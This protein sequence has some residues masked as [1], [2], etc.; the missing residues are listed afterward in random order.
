MRKVL[1]AILVSS[2]LLAVAPVTALARGDHHRRHDHAQQIRHRHFGMASSRVTDATE[3]QC[4]AAEREMQREEHADRD[5]GDRNDNVNEN[6]GAENSGA[7]NSGTEN[8]GNN[9]TGNDDNGNDNVEKND[10]GD[11]QRREDMCST[12]EHSSGAGD[13]DA[14]VTVARGDA[15]RSDVDLDR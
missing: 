1:F 11:D 13:G 5:R 9:N 8:S 3:I 15:G 7:E 2:A 4:E 12:A 6:S 10:Q 14:E